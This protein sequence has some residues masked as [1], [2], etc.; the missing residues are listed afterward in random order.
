MTAIIRIHPI[1]TVII[2]LY[3]PFLV[4]SLY[5]YYQQCIK[6]GI[7]Q[8]TPLGLFVLVINGIVATSLVPW[9]MVLNTLFFKLP[10]YIACMG[11]PRKIANIIIHTPLFAS[12]LYIF[13]LTINFLTGYVPI[14]FEKMAIW[15]VI[16][17]SSI[18]FNILFEF[19]FN[20]HSSQ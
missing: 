7:N 16:F 10:Y 18:W 19:I 1:L 14:P 15:I 17:L 2:I 3:I 6:S 12:I 4:Y 11:V 20:T 8:P 13:W 9:I 5:L